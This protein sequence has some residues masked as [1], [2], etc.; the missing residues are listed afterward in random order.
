M[1]RLLLALLPVA[2]A[3]ALASTAPAAGGL[4]TAIEGIERGDAEGKRE[5]GRIAAAGASKVRLYLNWASVAP[6]VRPTGFAAGDPDSEGYSWQEFDSR[7]DIAIA[8]SLEPI[9]V[10]YGA[11]RWAMR[12]RPADRRPWMRPDPVQFGLFAE[13]AATRYRGAQG[14]RPRIRLWQIWNEPNITVHLAP[15]FGATGLPTSPALYR[16][17]L[18]SAAAKLH[19]V[20][21]DNVVIAGGLS[22]FTIS[23]PDVE[24]VGPLRFMRDLLCVSKGPK[25][26]ATCATRVEF[27]VWAHHPY[28]SGGPTRSA[29]HPDDVS[30][31]DL[32][33]MRALLTAATRAGRVKAPRGVGFWVTEFSWD[34]K[35]PDPRGVPVAL[36]ARWVA[37]ALY[38][39]WDAG[40]SL[41]TWLMVRDQPYPRSSYQSG[42]YFRGA[43]PA[44]DR[45]KPAL[46]AFRFP[47]VAFRDERGVQIWART[48]GGK[49]G[50]VIVERKPAGGAWR[51]VAA[52]R[53]NRFGIISAKL[54]LKSAP[55]DHFRSRTATDSSVPFSL[56]QPPDRVVRPFG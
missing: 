4:E 39:M 13:A 56:T 19:A 24:S 20:R 11:P 42:L 23:F 41:A 46:R 10:L 22:P 44:G 29:A 33:E 32:K 27:D 30:L 2:A 55:S 16:S 36:H 8:N 49:P 47:F 45:P 15:Q 51:R 21:R 26:R 40:V 18:N 25:P 48:P 14:G 12:S 5:A 50:T 6:G 53:T 54:P 34:T 35:G 31:G 9:V 43:T 7:L 3:A 37:E 1:N 52:L 38:R 28:T 17:L